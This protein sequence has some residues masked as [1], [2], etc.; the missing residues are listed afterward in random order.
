[1]IIVIRSRDTLPA[2]VSHLPM[3]MINSG[4]AAGWRAT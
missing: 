4:W 3:T 1:L 2:G